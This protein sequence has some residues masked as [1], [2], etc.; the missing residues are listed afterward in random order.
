MEVIG[1]GGRHV[2]KVDEVRDGDFLVKRQ[3]GKDVYVPKDRASVEDQQVILD[4]PGNEI[5]YQNWQNQ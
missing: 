4:I 1:Q 2:G 5:S 3:L